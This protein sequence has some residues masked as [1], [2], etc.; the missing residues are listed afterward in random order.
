M[1]S[2]QCAK[3][4]ITYGGGFAGIIPRVDLTRSS[5]DEAGARTMDEACRQLLT[6]TEAH[7]PGTPRLGADMAHYRVEI[8]GANGEKHSF[9]IPDNA[10]RKGGALESSNI[11]AIVDQLADLARPAR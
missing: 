9:T 2:D 4:R 11:G 7:A 1:M 5:L 8:E 6:L 3:V 10:G